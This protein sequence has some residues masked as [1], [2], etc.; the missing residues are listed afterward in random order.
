[1]IRPRQPRLALEL[2]RRLPKGGE[3][4]LAGFL[5]ADRFP[6]EGD[7]WGSLPA[8]GHGVLVVVDYAGDEPKIRQ[9]ARLLAGLATCPPARIRLLLLDRDDLW[10]GRLL[11]QPAVARLMLG[12]R[13]ARL[14]EPV[15]LKP[16]AVGEEERRASWR[17]AAT[18]FAQALSVP[19]PVAVSSRL[20]GRRFDA[21]LLLHMQA[22]LATLGHGAAASTGDILRGLLHRERA[23]WRRRLVANGLGA[24][25]LP[26]VEAAVFWIGQ[27]GGAR[28]TGEA[29]RILGS[30]PLLRG[31]PALVLRQVAGLLRECYPEGEHGV[32]AMMPDP[33]REF[34]SAE[35][36]GRNGE[37]PGG[38]AAPSEAGA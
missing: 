32:A 1:L 12:S 10:L 21:V 3:P 34:F 36:L 20:A 4:W 23:Y 24:G 33:L 29:E 35:F 7:P 22:L 18:S 27:N 6:P 16:V 11:D 14:A 28:E 25:L 15:R 9:V 2:C 26:V 38:G 17:L 31:Q 13:T 37:V 8:S 30:I 19:S 5:R